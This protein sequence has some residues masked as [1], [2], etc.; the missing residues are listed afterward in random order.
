MAE[1]KNRKYTVRY[2]N[3]WVQKAIAG[4]KFAG[5]NPRPFILD[6][7]YFMIETKS[8]GTIINTYVLFGGVPTKKVHDK[9]TALGFAARRR[10][11]E[12]TD[13]KKNV[14]P[15]S[16]ND[17]ECYAVY[18]YLDVPTEEQLDFL[19]SLTLKGLTF[20][21]EKGKSFLLTTFDQIDNNWG[22]RDEWLNVFTVTDEDDSSDDDEEEDDEMLDEDDD[23]D[24]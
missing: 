23:F 10:P 14:H 22:D 16:G 12:W 19:S 11:A 15:V 24:L 21:K 5:Q 20:A 9:L 13:K 4:A 17:N 18:Y 2:V 6:T 3:E 1:K 8:D 7:R